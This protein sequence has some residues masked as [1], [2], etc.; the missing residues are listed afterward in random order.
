MS[1]LRIYLWCLFADFPRI[2]DE[3]ER[4]R[5]LILFHQLQISEPLGAFYRITNRKLRLCRFQQIRCHRILPVCGKAF[6]SFDD[7]RLREA[8]IVDEKF[9]TIRPASCPACVAPAEA[10]NS[11][12]GNRI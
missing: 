2:D 5:V 7:L 8:K 10:E 6:R 1:V 3:L 4:V 12:R 9:P 11:T